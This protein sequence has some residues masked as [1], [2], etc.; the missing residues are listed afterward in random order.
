VQIGIGTVEGGV[1]LAQR[2]RLPLTLGDVANYFRGADD[3]PF[4]S[5]IAEI[6]KETVRILPSFVFRFV[7]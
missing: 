4:A 3:L 7:S 2:L 1:G 6:V 5:R